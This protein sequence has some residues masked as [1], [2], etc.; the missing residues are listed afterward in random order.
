MIKIN[1]FK[2]I[3]SVECTD[4]ITEETEI[5]DEEFVYIFGVSYCEC[6]DEKVL[7]PHIMVRYNPYPFGEYRV[8]MG[9]ASLRLPVRFS[10]KDWESTVERL[11]R[12]CLLIEYDKDAVKFPSDMIGFRW[13]YRPL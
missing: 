13:N 5:V 1:Y 7:C 8:D 6:K 12:I 11:G 2:N 3:E 4:S 9:L 10:I